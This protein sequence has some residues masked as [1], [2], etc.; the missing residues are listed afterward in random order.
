MAAHMAPLF[1]IVVSCPNP[2]FWL[3]ESAVSFLA[4]RPSLLVFP[5]GCSQLHYGGCC[6]VRLQITTQ[7]FPSGCLFWGESGE[8]MFLVL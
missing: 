3:H 1:L 5:A 4:D 7:V 2:L 6:D 8:T